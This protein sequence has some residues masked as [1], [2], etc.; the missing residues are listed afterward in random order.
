MPLYRPVGGVIFRMNTKP[1]NDTNVSHF[2]SRLA[3]SALLACALVALCGMPFMSSAVAMEDP[4][5]ATA[6]NPA[7]AA[8]ETPATEQPVQQEQPADAAAQDP[9][10]AAQQENKEPTEEDRWAAL[11]NAPEPQ[12]SEATAAAIIDKGGNILYERNSEVEKSPASITKVMT[13]VVA[14]SSGM[15]L[16]DEVECVAPDLG[17]DAQMADLQKGDRLTFRDLLR[18]MLVYSANDAAYNVALH[19]GGSIPGF[20]DLM[21]AKAQELG[22]THSHFMNP[23]GIDED[24]HY[25]CAID[26]ARLSRYALENFPFIA[27]TVTTPWVEIP[28]HGEMR[29]FQSTDE[30]LSTYEGIRGVKTGYAENFTFMGASGR[31]PVSLYT[32]VLGCTTASG[33]F[34]DTAALMDWAYAKY[35]DWKISE[36]SWVIRTHPLALDLGY[37]VALSANDDYRGVVWPDGGAASY[38]STIVKDG[39]LLDPG[40]GYGWMD[41]TQSGRNMGGALYASR[42]VPVRTSAWPTFTLPLFET[43]LSLGEVGNA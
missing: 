25:S 34:S 31:G 42:P 27:Q 43:T 12:L 20:A 10:A 29:R 18:V 19:V 24:G 38:T 16:D 17:P 26:L 1:L 7:A 35:G 5:A 32:A 11:A 41:W 33:R 14:L 23:H 39:R 21:N 9:N 15:S 22:M 13:A 37:K 36:D 4:E 6:E 30:L 40:T 2:M 28:V 3:A 8:A